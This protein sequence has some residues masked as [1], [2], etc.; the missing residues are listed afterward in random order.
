MRYLQTIDQ[1]VGGAI[2]VAGWFVLENLEY[3][4]SEVI[5]KPW[6][7]SSTIDFEKLKKVTSNYI[8]II[9]DN[10]FY[11]GFE[12][13][14]KIFSEKLGTKIIELHNVG[15]IEQSELPIALEEL[16]GLIE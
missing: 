7:D 3:E 8:E 9:S 2:F 14:K 4:E 5:A 16:L 12:E 10:D 13:N 1:K 6:V 15:H 11:G